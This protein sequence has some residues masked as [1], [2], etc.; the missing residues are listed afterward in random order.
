MQRITILCV[1]R[2]NQKFYAQGVAEYQK[3]LQGVCQFSVVEIGEELIHEKNA[4][5][6]LIEK[7]LEKEEAKLMA[8]IPK[9]ARCVALCVEGKQLSSEQLAEYMEQ[10]PLSGSGDIVFVIGSSHGLG[11]GLIGQADMKL[12]LSKMTFP[13]QMARLILAE[14][15][16][17]GFMIRSKSRYHK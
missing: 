8:A 13:H 1:G 10:A 9:G 15:I 4:S 11:K 5:T 14:Q 16:Y 7:A 12:S 17:R 3:R 2:L 6:L